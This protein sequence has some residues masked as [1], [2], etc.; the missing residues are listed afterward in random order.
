MNM[1]DHEKIYQSLTQI[2]WT[3]KAY[4]YALADALQQ[5][6]NLPEIAARIMAERQ[7]LC[8][9]AEAFLYP[10]LKHNLPNPFSLKD[11]RKAADRMAKAVLAGESIGLMGDYDVDGATSTALLKMFLESCGVTVHCFI[12]DREDGY[13]PNSQKMKEFK[14]KGCSVI[15]TLDCGT[16]AF[17]AIADG[18]ALGLDVLVLDH[19]DPDATRLPN[20]YALVNPKRLDE[21]IHHPCRYLAAV[22]VVF[23][24]TVA[25]NAILREKG[26]YQ[27]RT[28]PNLM[29]YLDLV[30]FGTVCD[31]V[32][33]SG[34][35]RLFVKSG[36]K[37]MRTGQNLGIK[38]L[39]ELVQIKEPPDAHHLGYVF[40]PRINACGRVGKS[41]IGMHLLSAG[42]SVQAHILA[43]ELEELNN[44]RREIESAVL[45]EA[46]RQVESTGIHTPFIVVEGHNWHQGV[47]GIVAGRLKDKYNLP[48]FAL[49]IENDEVKGSSRSVQ[50]VDLGSLVMNA[51]Q[52]GILSRGGGHPMAAGFSLKESNLPIFKQ[53]LLENIKPEMLE[54]DGQKQYYDAVISISGV[55][56]SLMDS[57]ALLA[58]FGESNPEPVFMIK[59][60]F[61][62]RSLLL[63]NG[64]ISCT[65]TAPS[66]ISLNAIA[67]RSLG[68]PVGDFLLNQKQTPIYAVGTLKREF[69]RDKKRI[70][71]QLLDIILP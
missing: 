61:I 11:M 12:P 19:H 7:I 22:G 8:D 41:D 15:A 25:L 47:V 26:F 59:N 39:A 64:H 36:L 9:E 69:W 40:G 44:T 45:H 24:F 54:T 53:Y 68:T 33:L 31:V 21:D 2:Q 32:K 70:Q 13:G 60:V 20:A 51:I 35:N 52:K 1:P 49:S 56:D 42:D 14:E 34:V 30:A 66:G 27:K 3:E 46:V 37:Q 4:N 17:E 50:G 23:L 62:T 67:F 6:F 5:K 57:L 43:Q 28:E 18:M 10:T 55:T 38:A 65:L 58:P 16:T 29:I 63:K 71:L 48:V